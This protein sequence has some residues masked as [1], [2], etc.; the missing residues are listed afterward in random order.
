M[1]EW[2]RVRCFQC[3][4]SRYSLLIWLETEVLRNYQKPTTKQFVLI[5]NDDVL[6]VLE[7]E[8][9]KTTQKRLRPT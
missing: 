2:Q 1:N 8:E 9:N 3:L 5:I 4:A 7:A 6:K